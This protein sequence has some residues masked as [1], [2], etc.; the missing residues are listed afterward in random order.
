M[1]KR[2]KTETPEMPM[3]KTIRLLSLV[4]I[5]IAAPCLASEPD[6]VESLGAR[7]PL[8]SVIPFIGMLLSIALFP[9]FG[10]KFHS[11]EKFWVRHFGEVSAFW[12]LLVAVP[13]VIIFGQPAFYQLKRVL[14]IDYIPFII[15]LLALYTVS[16]GIFIEGRLKGTPAMNVLMLLIGTL[17]ASCMGTTGASMLMIRPV[18]RANAFRKDKKHVVVFFIFLV[19]NIGGSLTPLGDPPLFLG[20]LHGVPFFWTLKMLPVMAFAA[21]LILTVFFV[22][23]TVL[24]RKELSTHVQDESIHDKKASIRILGAYNLFFILGIICTVL[25]SGLLR[26]GELNVLGIQMAVQDILRDV[27]LLIITVLSLKTTRI[28]IHEKNEFH[29]GPIKEV[30]ILFAG[31]FVTI[32]PALLI[33]KAGVNGSMAFIIRSVKEPSSYF[34]AAGG[35]SSFLDNAPTYLTFFNTA[36]GNF[37]QGL[38]ENHAVL[39]LIAE[40]SVYLEAISA[41]AVFMGANTYIGNAP[42]FMV[43]TIAEEKRWGV[44]MPHFFGYMGYSIAIL[45]PTFILVTLIFF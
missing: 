40:K 30:G 34:W 35:L 44:K 13:L 28:E 42:N 21:A 32:I 22:M 37:Y 29:F 9:L 38:P 27:V 5:Y 16:G 4:F 3:K 12:G 19:S 2:G 20:F 17:L 1:K 26:L 7:L 31:I 11:V 43:K 10:Q 25:L 39:R 8:W 14:L 23:D 41:G 24:Y 45:I 33:L 15:L 36:L 18:L 6:T